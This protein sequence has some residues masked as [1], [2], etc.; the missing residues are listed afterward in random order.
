MAI[1]FAGSDYLSVSD[2]G[3]SDETILITAWGYINSDDGATHA[4]AFAANSAGNGGF[5][6]ISAMS[7]P[8]P[9]RATKY[10]ASGGSGSGALSVNPTATWFASA[11]YFESN[12][13]RYAY[14]DGTRGTQNTT[15]VTDPSL[16]TLSVGARVNSTVADYLTGRV[17][18]VAIYTGITLAEADAIHAAQAAG[19]S[20]LLCP[21]ADAIYE[22]WPLINAAN[23]QGL[24]RGLTLSATG[25]PATA[26]HP[27][28]V[29]PVAR[30]Y[31]FPSAGAAS[32]SAK[33][34]PMQDLSRQFAGYAAARLGGLLQ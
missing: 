7:G 24:I 21:R 3:I 11:A 26:A 9:T 14:R 4:L 10:N 8:N 28:I 32:A 19:Y 2:S 1:S 29:R 18:E 16:N 5:G 30:I 25:S 27:R 31:N 13:S 23:L 6:L 33:P 17:A 20:P 34:A 22:Y 12:T 15:S